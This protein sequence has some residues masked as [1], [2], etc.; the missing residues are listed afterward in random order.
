[1][2]FAVTHLP[3]GGLLFQ[4]ARVF[5]QKICCAAVLAVFRFVEQRPA[6]SGGGFCARFIQFLAELLRSRA[7]YGLHESGIGEVPC[8]TSQLPH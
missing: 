8:I 1:M 6:D 2:S 7:R 3:R 5:I 4:R